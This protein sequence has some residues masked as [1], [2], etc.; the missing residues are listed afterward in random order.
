MI[1]GEEKNFLNEDLQ[2]TCGGLFKL[3]KLANTNL[4]NDICD[5]YK[6]VLCTNIKQRKT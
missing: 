6:I 4:E 3:C 2:L 1:F 5:N